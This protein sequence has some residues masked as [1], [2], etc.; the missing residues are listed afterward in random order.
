MLNNKY[1][2]NSRR[3]SRIQI[4]NWNSS[5]LNE[6]FFFKTIQNNCIPLVVGEC[7]ECSRTADSALC[8]FNV[9]FSHTR[10]HTYEHTHVLP[11]TTAAAAPHLTARCCCC[12]CCSFSSYA[13][14]HTHGR[15]T[16]GCWVWIITPTL[17]C[18]LLL[19]PLSR[20]R[21]TSRLSSSALPL[22]M[23]NGTGYG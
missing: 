22:H 20:S 3:K 14:T 9:H 8:V 5:I 11:P 6:S 21:C 19:L 2:F 10:T 7:S 4:S 18:L 1:Q 16:R 23:A 13:H 15:V 17:V 12:C